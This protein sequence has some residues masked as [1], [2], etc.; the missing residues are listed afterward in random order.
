MPTSVPFP[1]EKPCKLCRIVKPLEAFPL[2]PRTK[3]GRRSKCRTCEN[4]RSDPP[5]QRRYRAEH[6]NHIQSLVQ[7]WRAA[8]PERLRAHNRISRQR[9]RARAKTAEGRYTSDDLAALYQAQAGLCA[10]CGLSLPATYHVDHKMPLVRG[11]THW[12]DNLCLACERCNKRKGAS[13]ISPG[14]S[15]LCCLYQPGGRATASPRL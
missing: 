11:G 4:K 1:L 6:A 12:P 15:P 13:V 10:Y 3:D 14:G 9:R 8:H 5:Y 7:E 2:H